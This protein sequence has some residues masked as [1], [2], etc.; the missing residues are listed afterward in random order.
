M[1]FSLFP[2]LAPCTLAV[3]LA[4]PPEPDIPDGT[5]VQDAASSGSTDVGGGGFA[6]AKE[7]PAEE[8]ASSDATEL[9]LQF[10]GIFN[11][12]NSQSL[13]ITG[14]SNFRL[15]RKA[16]QAAA[17]VAG[18]YG[19]SVTGD[20]DKWQTTVGNVQGMVRYDW[21]AHD[22][23]SL[24]MM[25]TGRHDEFQGLDFRLNVDPGV[26]LYALTNPKHRLWFEVGYDFQYDLRTDEAILLYD[27]DGNPILDMNGD[28]ERLDKELLNH[29]VRLFGGYSNR[30]SEMVTFDTGIEYLQIVLKGR[31]FRVNWNTALATQ[32]AGKFSLA[33]TF[34]LRYE[35]DPLPDIKK[36]DTITDLNLVYRFF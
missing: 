22:R 29:A 2:A 36:L 33:A 7:K 6:T 27:D 24:F 34:T 17:A 10:G 9:D 20:D 8:E 23:V 28:Q 16:H 25:L 4:P 13:A 31:R 11:T 19:R 15:R 32:I 14:A 35:N 5:G 21:F 18:N 3:A 26:A 30:L 12:G 1:P